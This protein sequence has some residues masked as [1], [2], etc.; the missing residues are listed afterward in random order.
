MKVT[1]SV[2]AMIAAIG[3][4]EA[5]GYVGYCY[6][7]ND[8]DLRAMCRAKEHREP[9]YCYSIRQTDLRAQCLAETRRK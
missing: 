1:A 5:D 9:S 8:P 6:S 2:L 7:I 4:S 3:A